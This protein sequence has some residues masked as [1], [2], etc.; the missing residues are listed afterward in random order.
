[1]IL[2][3]ININ[4]SD[5]G[6]FLIDDDDFLMKP[7]KQNISKAKKALKRTKENHQDARFSKIIEK[8]IRQMF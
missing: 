7:P 6:E 8:S 4:S 1:M 3:R 5:E 2:I